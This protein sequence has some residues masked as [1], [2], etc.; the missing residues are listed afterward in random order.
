MRGRRRC[1]P[2]RCK[3]LRAPLD[4]RLSASHGGVAG[5]E[6]RRT[7][8]VASRTCE[9]TCAGADDSLAVRT[10]QRLSA[11][12]EVQRCRI[13][14]GDRPANSSAMAVE[15]SRWLGSGAASATPREHHRAV[16]VI[17][18]QLQRGMRKHGASAAWRS[19]PRPR[20]CIRE[21]DR[22]RLEAR[23]VARQRAGSPRRSVPEHS[24]RTQI[25]AM[26][27]R[28]LGSSRA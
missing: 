10:G 11:A 24:D 2:G 1:T 8:V 6:R 5:A 16:G 13:E 26:L 4:R 7:A 22:S 19:E 17:E 18:R 25:R 14:E 9:P 20:R 12:L 21:I 27:H 28:A 23:T 15:V 3:T